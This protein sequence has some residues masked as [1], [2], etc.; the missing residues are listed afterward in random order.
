[1]DGDQ[2]LRF[3]RARGSAGGCGLDRGDF[4]RQ[5]N[6]QKV[7][8]ALQ[9]K[10]TSADTLMNIGKVTSLMDAL[11]QNLRTNFEISEIRTLLSLGGDISSDKIISIDLVSDEN[12]L[13]VSGN[14]AGAGSIQVPRAGTFE[15]SEIKAFVQKKLNANEITKED[16]HVALFNASGIEGYATRQS[17]RLEK[18]GFNISAI[19]NAPTGTFEKIEIYDI[20]KK[21]SATKKKLEAIYGVKVKTSKSPISVTND[22]DFVII[23]AKGSSAN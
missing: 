16:A 8:K 1:M 20:T 14:I 2:A 12:Q 18:Q 6:Q 13:I 23:F 21:K 5:M 3:S 11:G 10:A 4:D 15:Y 22:T 19:G 9:Q 17:E 7:L